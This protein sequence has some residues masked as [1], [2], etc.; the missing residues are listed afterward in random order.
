MIEEGY[1]LLILEAEPLPIL[2]QNCCPFT[3]GKATHLQKGKWIPI[4]LGETLPKFLG[5]EATTACLKVEDRYPSEEGQLF[6]IFAEKGTSM[7]ILLGEP[8]RN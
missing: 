7:A 2:R 1:L 5:E 6:P 8:L 4:L 3:G